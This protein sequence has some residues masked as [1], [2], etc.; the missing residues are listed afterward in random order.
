MANEIAEAISQLAVAISEQNAIARERLNRE[1]PPIDPQ[2][3]THS[4]ELKKA[5]E[6]LGRGFVSRHQMHLIDRDKCDREGGGLFINTSWD[7]PNGN[8]SEYEERIR[9]SGKW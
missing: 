2:A 7:I 5:Y 1:M 8:Y 4:E 3:R 6:A 9:P